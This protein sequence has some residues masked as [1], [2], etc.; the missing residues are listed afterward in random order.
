MALVVLMC[1]EPEFSNEQLFGWFANRWA[2]PAGQGRSLPKN[3]LT[4][5]D[6]AVA[7]LLIVN[8]VCDFFL[9]L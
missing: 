9:R 6:V 7:V 8:Q 5:D 3:A 1:A 4:S 2:G